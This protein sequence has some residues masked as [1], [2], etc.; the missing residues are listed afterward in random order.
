MRNTNLVSNLE[1]KMQE[2]KK[3]LLDSNNENP[4][5]HKRSIIKENKTALEN[6]KML[7]NDVRLVSLSGKLEIQKKKSGKKQNDFYLDR[8][9]L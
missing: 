7:G 3:Y 9:D 2:E 6:N 4:R 1:I 8:N 5:F